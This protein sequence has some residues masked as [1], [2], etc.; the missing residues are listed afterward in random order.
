MKVTQN[1]F[2]KRVRI[3]ISKVKL[4]TTITQVINMKKLKLVLILGQLLKVLMNPK[5]YVHIEAYS[6]LRQKIVS[7]I[8]MKK[9]KFVTTLILATF[10]PLS[11]YDPQTLLTLD[12]KTLGEMDYVIA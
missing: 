6:I 11:V 3:F 9:V 2:V 8:N 5:L 7:S 10:Y 4:I 1:L 12:T